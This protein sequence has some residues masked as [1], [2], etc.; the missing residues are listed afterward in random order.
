[1]ILGLGLDIIETA[2]LERA[3]SRHGSRFEER[4][5]TP[6]E[7][8]VCSS[9]ADRIQALAAR[10]A[11]KE[12]CLKALGTGWSGGLTFRQIEVRSGAGGR[13]EIQ[14]ADDAAAR[15]RAMGVRAIHLSIT[16][17]PGTAAAVVVLE[18]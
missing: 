13:P 15:A 10:F 7:V 17:Q 16:H 12:A 6:A 11:A 4:V 14:L 2:R 3:L 1:M 8:G 18:G 5:Y 9:R